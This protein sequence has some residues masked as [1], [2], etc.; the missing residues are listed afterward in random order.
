MTKVKQA[1]LSAA[2][3]F[4]PEHTMFYGRHSSDKCYCEEM[5]GEVMNRHVCDRP[6]LCLTNRETA[7]VTR[8]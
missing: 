8:R 1:E 5:Y 2:V 3:T 4:L 6:N 7:T